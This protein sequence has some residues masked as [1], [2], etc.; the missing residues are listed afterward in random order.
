MH[1]PNIDLEVPIFGRRV[2]LGC[3]EQE[4]AN[5]RLEELHVVYLGVIIRCLPRT[6]DFQLPQLYFFAHT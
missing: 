3:A 5:G 4:V 6:S 1:T 2:H